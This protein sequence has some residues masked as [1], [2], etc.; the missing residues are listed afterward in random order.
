MLLQNKLKN[1]TKSL[2]KPLDSGQKI[3]RLNI[4]LPKED[5]EDTS[6]KKKI[7]K[8]EKLFTQ[9]FLPENKK[10][11][12]KNKLT[13]LKNDIPTLKSSPILVQESIQTEKTLKPFWTE[14]LKEKSAQ[15]WLPTKTD[16]QDSV[17]HSYNLYVQGLIPNSLLKKKRTP[18]NLK[19]YKKTLCRYL[20]FSPQ[21]TTAPE[22]MIYSRKI[23]IFPNKEQKELFEKCFGATRFFYNKAV[24]C[25]NT[26]YKEQYD[27]YKNS[28]VCLEC[29][30]EKEE[31][32]LTCKK[33]KPKWNLP[34]NIQTLRPL[35]MKSDK[36][37]NEDELWMKEIPYDTRQLILRD[38]ITSFK[39]CITN[40]KRG[41]IEKFKV[42]FKSKKDLR[43]FFHIDKKAVKNNKGCFS[44]FT[45]RLKNNSKLKSKWNL[46]NRY[47]NFD[48][49]NNCKIFKENGNYYFIVVK[50][51]KTKIEKAPKEIVSLD[52]GVRS[53]QTFYSEDEIGNMGENVLKSLEKKSKK[54]DFYISLREKEK[55][56]LK[57]YHLQSKIRL[58]RAKISNRITDLHYQSCS[59]LVKNY[60]HIII[61]KFGVKSMSAKKERKISKR[62]V[63]EM[64]QLSHFKFRM[65]LIEKCK[66]YNRN[67]YVV[68]EE[69]TSKT[70]GKCGV[71]NENLGGSKTFE[72]PSCKLCIDRDVNGARNILLKTLWG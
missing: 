16:S 66:E 8:E 40:K 65:R 14:S 51:R 58:L 4:K 29:K 13:S 31:D 63:K 20:Q 26:S 59:Y 43:H 36:D 47:K 62:T 30:G 23:Q 69:Y 7:K 21:D 42:G 1:S 18:L 38:V 68:T 22:N 64:L 9:E 49:N 15:L 10:K 35:V 72:C 54:I 17:S 41:N 32:S 37:L 61:P 46:Y 11:T 25:I 34:L 6:S 71:I 19:N 45:R 55:K 52:P 28:E 44:I 50:E 5:I 3:E 2:G 33:H 48:I 53:F 60:Q 67:L 24:E 27:N 39:S 56:R 70:C 12:L 57:K